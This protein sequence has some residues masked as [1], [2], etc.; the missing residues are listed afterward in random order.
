MALSLTEGEPAIRKTPSPAGFF[1]IQRRAVQEYLG[2][3]KPRIPD[4]EVGLEEDKVVEEALK[5]LSPEQRE[6]L[7]LEEESLLGDRG[8]E[9]ASQKDVH[10]EI[11]P[12]VCERCQGLRHHRKAESIFH[13]SVHS[14]AEIIDESPHKYNHVYHLVDAADFPMSLVPRLHVLLGDINLRTQNRR[15]R[16]EKFYGNRKIDMSFI[17]TRSDL[18]APKAEQ[19]NALMPYLREVLRDALGRVGNRIRLG[20][21]RCVSANRGWW[22]SELKKEIYQRGGAGWMVGKANVGKS[23]LFEAVFPKGRMR[24]EEHRRPAISHHSLSPQQG[25]PV[26]AGYGNSPSSAAVEQPSDL[27]V[28]EWLPPSRPETEYPAMP[29]VSSLPGTTAS[30]IRIPFGNGKGELV[31]LPGL[32]RSDLETH[33]QPAH[34][35]SLVMKSRIKPV[36]ETLKPGQSLLLG[37]FIRITPRTP[38]LVFL[39]ASF[40]PLNTHVTS[41]EKAIGIQKQESALDVENISVPGTGEKIQHAGSFTLS[42]DIT[43]QSAGPLTRKDALKL[44]PHELPFRVLAI[45]IL[46]EGVGWVEVMAQVRTRDCPHREAP[47][48][49]PRQEEAITSENKAGREVVEQKE[50]EDP[51]AALNRAAAGGGE[52][53]VKPKAEPAETRVLEERHWP[54]IDVFTPEGRFIGSRRPMGGYML[55]KA[56]KKPAKKMRTSMK[57][58]KKREKMSR[59]AGAAM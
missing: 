23:R 18:L 39:A 31:D 41:T 10:T 47:R 58:A 54:V 56:I 53:E 50:V 5:N 16:R 11:L 29:T 21:V 44:K 30:P 45:D 26:P 2:L 1:N 48:D 15:S 36:K 20:N 4:P 32:A 8:D 25:L 17:I 14:I 34:H 13:P 19:V 7:G 38:G 12:P 57:G 59:R 28:G 51:W 6:A 43:S 33:V 52:T 49:H 46:I 42:H 40:T 55:N 3:A 27:H 22:T 35:R 9:N 24:P 37:G